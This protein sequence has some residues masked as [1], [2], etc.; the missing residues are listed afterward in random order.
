MGSLKLTQWIGEQIGDK[1]LVPI[2]CHPKINWHTSHEQ[3]AAWRQIGKHSTIWITT[4]RKNSW[5][6]SNQ[7]SP[8]VPIT[9]YWARPST[10][11]N[12]LFISDS[13]IPHE[14]GNCS[15]TETLTDMNDFDWVGTRLC[16]CLESWLAT[17][18]SWMSWRSGKT[19]DDRRSCGVPGSPTTFLT[20]PRSTAQ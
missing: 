13:G 2:M 19:N 17:L 10:K 5:N 4:E 14:H 12:A 20:R 7:I 15:V 11:C 8:S 1:H 16:I 18:S 3:L 6:D 9:V